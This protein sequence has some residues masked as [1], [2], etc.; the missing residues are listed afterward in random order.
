MTAEG[1]RAKPLDFGAYGVNGSLDSFGR[2][3]ALNTFHPR[4]GYVTLTSADPF[5]EP[6]RY[7]P[8]AVRA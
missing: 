3:I 6:E 2:L 7:N 5:P 8:A 1:G 4:H